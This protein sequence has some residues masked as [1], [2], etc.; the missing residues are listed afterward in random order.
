MRPSPRHVTVLAAAML[1]LT[2][3]HR[4]AKPDTDTDTAVAVA[5]S[6]I[7]AQVTSLQGGNWREAANVARDK[8]RHPAQ[9]LDFFGVKP[10]MT[11]I[12]I[13]PSGGWYTELLAPYL[14]ANGHYV[15]VLND[16]Q[17]ATTD[18]NRTGWADTEAKLRAKV[19]ARADVYGTPTFVL[20][21]PAKPSF[22]APESVDAVLTFRNVHNW[23]MA[24]TEGDMFEAF[25]EVLKPG[26][27]L[28]VVDHRARA[29]APAAEMKTSGYLPEEAVIAMAIRAG[30]RL[31][32]RS[33]INANPLDTADWP[34][35]V[36]TLP[37]RLTLGDK[38][39]EKYLAIGESDR[40]TLRFVK[41]AE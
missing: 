12:E 6:P 40:M 39:R 36:W 11:V 10:D 21:D 2:A 8:Y 35:G 33:E 18:K 30:F 15:A 9:T 26:G 38:D 27:V 22:G 7:V 5:A 14:R 23:V 28:G 24:G 1:A 13:W 29:G 19:A 4:D 16:P 37:P 41:P 17:F 25:F 3:C 34:D 20:I 32:A 31:D